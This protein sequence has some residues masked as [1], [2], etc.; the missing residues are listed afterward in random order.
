MNVFE[1][2]LALGVPPGVVEVAAMVLATLVFA[3]ATVSALAIVW[4][5]ACGL[6]EE[7]Y[8][9]KRHDETQGMPPLR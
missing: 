2:A 9:A 6:V 3:A 8:L 7:H 4:R 5:H 1:L